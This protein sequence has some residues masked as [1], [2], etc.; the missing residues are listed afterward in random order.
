[1]HL[2]V[3]DHRIWSHSAMAAAA[4]VLVPTV[5]V[6]IGWY[7]QPTFRD[8]DMSDVHELIMLFVMMRRLPRWR[9]RSGCWR[10]PPSPST[11][12]YAAKRP[13]GSISCSVPLSRSQCC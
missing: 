6:T 4:F 5:I 10:H 3:P 11:V 8:S 9:C 7:V 12:S 1:M 13:G 2:G